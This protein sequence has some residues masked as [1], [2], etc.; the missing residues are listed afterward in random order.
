MDD[1]KYDDLISHRVEVDRVGEAS[2]E[3]A[4]SLALD[5]GVRQGHLKDTG[6]SPVDLRRKGLAEPRAL[7]L[8]PITGIE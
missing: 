2:H 5:S 8:V 4:P 6:K 3:G 1:C 7:L